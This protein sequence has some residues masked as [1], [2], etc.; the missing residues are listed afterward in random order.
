MFGLPVHLMAN[1]LPHSSSYQGI[2]A[3][4]WPSS[5]DSFNSNQG[6]TTTTTTIKTTTTATI[7]PEHHTLC[8]PL[9]NQ[10]EGISNLT[11]QARLQDISLGNSRD[12]SSV[13]GPRN[14]VNLQ[15]TF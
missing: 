10:G 14:K 6:P 7:G 3:S 1:I 5:Q 8:N 4:S 15:D 9:P 2:G 11:P 12:T 13:M